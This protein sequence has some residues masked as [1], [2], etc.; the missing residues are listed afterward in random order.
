M[1]A[2]LNS[3]EIAGRLQEVA[4]W[5]QKGVEIGRTFEFATFVDAIAF[6]GNV[7]AIAEDLNHHP[8]I[9]I[10][11]RRVSIAVSTHSAGGLTELDFQLAAR[12]NKLV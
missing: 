2:L 10:R 5:S 9:D 12:L 6:V 4:G 1:P 3:T 7:A 11:Y 8:D